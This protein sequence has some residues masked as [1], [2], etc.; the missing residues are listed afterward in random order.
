[1][2]QAFTSFKIVLGTLFCAQEEVASW[3]ALTRSTAM[4]RTMPCMPVIN[5]LLSAQSVS[6]KHF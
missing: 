4:A 5:F 6:K 1:L 3:M 2:K